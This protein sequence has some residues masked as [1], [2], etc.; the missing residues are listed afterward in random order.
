M[1]GDGAVEMFRQL[2]GEIAGIREDFQ[3]FQLSC[4][5]RHG[6]IG[7]ALGS[8]AQQ[9]STYAHDFS[10]HMDVHR[11]AEARLRALEDQATRE[12]AQRIH[13][14]LR[15][16]EAAKIALDKNLAETAAAAER[17]RK[18]WGRIIPALIGLATGGGAALAGN[19]LK[20][21]IQ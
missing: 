14:R 3:K 12:E 15:E 6:G 9:L 8:M 18:I 19:F 5:E 16:L 10:R 7:P 21:M 2:L 13:D 17:E 1:P 20:A 4:V 11:E